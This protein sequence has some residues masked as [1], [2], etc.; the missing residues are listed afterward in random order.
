[1]G[2][3]RV[4]AGLGFAAIGSAGFVQAPA[5][6]GTAPFLLDGNRVYADI[7]FVRPD[8]SIHRAL[9]FVDTGSGSMEIAAGLFKKL[10]L[11]PGRPL[12]FRVGKLV[13]EVPAGE[14]TSDPSEPVAM[15]S[16]LKL[17]AM[18][19]AGVLQRYVV[20]LDYRRRLI[21]LA[22]PGAIKP[23]GVPVPFRRN[24][25]TGLIAVDAEINGASY[26]ITIDNGSAY[27]WVRQETARVWLAARPGWERGVGAV[28][29]SNMVMAGWEAETRG[30]LLRIPEV[31]IGPVTLKNVGALA[32]GPGKGPGGLDL[33]DWYSSK[34]PVPVIGFIGGNVLKA[35]RLTIDYAGGRMYWLRQQEPDASDQNQVGMTLRKQAGEYSVA[36]V[37]TK[38]GKPTV[39]GVQPGDTLIRIDGLETKNASKG[40]IYDALHGKPGEVRELVVERG[41]VRRT[42]RATVTAF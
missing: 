16:G 8:G 27:T 36:G 20:V 28:G 37:A 23:E 3:G 24:P 33:F 5:V 42:V 15:G 34:N 2:L 10:Q 1:L 7:S 22:L 29:A 11:D 14:V 17:E 26:P 30:T 9:A 18:L 12:R 13:V 38:G 41:G 32:A 6:E 40:Q 25:R 31:R 4:L 39:E 19:S 35:F 21:T